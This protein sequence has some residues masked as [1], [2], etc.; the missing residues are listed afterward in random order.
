MGL[1]LFE[2]LRKKAA[3][4]AADAFFPRRGKTFSCSRF[5]NRRTAFSI[6]EDFFNPLLSFI[7]RV[8]N[9][10]FLIWPSLNRYLTIKITENATS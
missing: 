2:R 9:E 1:R 8:F 3:A 6:S 5:L 10:C 4:I 7:L